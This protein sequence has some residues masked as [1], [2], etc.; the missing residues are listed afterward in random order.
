MSNLPLMTAQV[1]RAPGAAQDPESHPSVRNLLG[2]PTVIVGWGVGVALSAYT[3]YFLVLCYPPLLANDTETL[4]AVV[5]EHGTV[6]VTGV[7]VGT[8]IVVLT[9]SVTI[10]V[11]LYNN[12]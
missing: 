12:R 10:M 8:V 9:L 3:T 4:H 11:R 1:H 5:A 6:L 7:L 2:L